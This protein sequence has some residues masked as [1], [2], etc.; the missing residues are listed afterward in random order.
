MP[1]DLRRQPRD[2]KPVDEALCVGESHGVSLRF[3][4]R[5]AMPSVDASVLGIVRR[6]AKPRQ[7]AAQVRLVWKEREQGF[8]SV[9]GVACSSPHLMLDHLV[10]VVE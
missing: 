5:F 10:Y 2:E 9:F 6:A 7:L 1:S 8:P 3:A 4:L